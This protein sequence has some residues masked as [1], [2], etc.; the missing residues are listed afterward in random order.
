MLYY[1]QCSSIALNHVRDVIITGANAV[2]ITF[3]RFS[4]FLF[5]SSLQG[6]QQRF[7]I[8]VRLFD[9]HLA[10][11]M[12]ENDYYCSKNIDIYIW[13]KIAYMYEFRYIKK[14]YIIA[15][16]Y[17][18]NNKNILKKLNFVQENV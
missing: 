15:H 2:T 8:A 7:G 18:K 5:L 1:L 4:L 11:E 3:P 17:L 12:P 14:G 10:H 9:L 13:K 6:K 16:I